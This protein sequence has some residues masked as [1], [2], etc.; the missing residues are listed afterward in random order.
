MYTPISTV[1]RAGFV[2]F[3]VA[4]FHLLNKRPLQYPT[5]ELW[6]LPFVKRIDGF[7]RTKIPPESSLVVACSIHAAKDWIRLRPT[8]R[9]PP[10][11]CPHSEG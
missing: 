10:E 9:G 5:R 11:V 3:P 4:L 8:E 2:L 1:H 7:R 6:E